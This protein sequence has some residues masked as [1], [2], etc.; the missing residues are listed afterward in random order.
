MLGW[1]VILITISYE[2]N[3]YSV[4]ILSPATEIVKGADPEIKAA[5]QLPFLSQI[6]KWWSKHATE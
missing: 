2:T 4:L 1:S 6:Q 3:Q 5:T